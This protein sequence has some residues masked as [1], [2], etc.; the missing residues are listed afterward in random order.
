M[1]SKQIYHSFIKFLF[2]AG[3]DC[4]GFKFLFITQQRKYIMN[5]S[6]LLLIVDDEEEV[7]LLLCKFAEKAGFSTIGAGNGRTALKMLT[8]YDPNVILSDIQMPE[9]DGMELLNELKQQEINIPVII[10]TAFATID[11]A[12]DAMKLGASD[13]I[14][15]PVNFDYLRQVIQR[16]LRQ[17]EL[18]K[19]VR[20]HERQLKN[21]LRLATKVQ[22]CMLPSEFDDGRIK[23]HFRY[24]PLIEIGGDY[25]TTKQ[26]EDGSLIAALYDVTGHG[27]SAA[28]IASMIHFQLTDL[29]I[30][31]HE[32]YHII[33][34][35]NNLTVEK[36]SITGLFCTMALIRIDVQN[37]ELTMVNAGHPEI[38]VW[39]N[40]ENKIDC[41][42]SQILPIGLQ[43][44]SLNQSS[45]LTIPIASGDKIIL[46]TDGFTESRKE[47]GDILGSERFLDIIYQAI[48]HP[49]KE[50]IDQIFKQ[51]EDY[52]DFE[53]ADDLTLLTFEI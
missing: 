12:V 50:M 23:M 41:I 15:K 44:A 28:L 25:L 13:F 5:K 6:P 19:K 18:E 9:M 10:M 11:R 37:G 33:E 31:S 38:F 52:R 24:E 29:F 46:Y 8:Q 32:P 30:Q 51:V 34:Q 27:V 48:D 45:Q 35:I 36:F 7:R 43:A 40:K 2:D 42:S 22:Q 39:R 1:E 53:P 47:N 17:S 16:V 14:T 20:E 4:Y 49:P 3:E 21:D 26:Y